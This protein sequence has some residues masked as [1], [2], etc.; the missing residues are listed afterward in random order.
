MANKI[1]LIDLNLKITLIQEMLNFAW[2]F[3]PVWWTRDLKVDVFVGKTSLTV[4]QQQRI[5]R[6]RCG[7][8]NQF[9]RTRR[10]KEHRQKNREDDLSFPS[11]DRKSRLLT[12]NRI[13]TVC[14]IHWCDGV[15][16]LCSPFLTD[17]K[18]IPFS[19]QYSK[20]TVNLEWPLI[21]PWIQNI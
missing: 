7:K 17:L 4:C 14:V 13:F 6:G 18:L 2:T 12:K 21:W 15:I 19:L 8:R 3:R 20:E 11:T 9:W 10:S 16:H 1:V 5:G